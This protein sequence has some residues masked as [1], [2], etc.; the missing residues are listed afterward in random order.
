MCRASPPTWCFSANMGP[1]WSTTTGY[2]ASV[3]PIAHS[4]EL[5]WSSCRISL[6]GPALRPGRWSNMVGTRVPSP[7]RRQVIRH[8][9][10]SGLLTVRRTTTL[11]P[12]KL[13]GLWPL[14]RR[15]MSPTFPLRR[16]L[17]CPS[18]LL[19]ERRLALFRP[20]QPR[21]TSQHPLEQLSTVRHGHLLC[22]RFRQTGGD[23][24]CRCRCR[25]HVSPHRISLCN[26]YRT[27]TLG[28][29]PVVPIVAGVPI[30]DLLLLF[31]RI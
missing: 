28:R 17:R 4:V 24:P 16:R 13:L 5:A 29:D 3:S 12:G 26:R 25:Y 6:T 1:S 9:R 31:G 10:P 11:R 30:V 8:H 20:G 14:L 18:G 21:R 7:V 23:R 19:A 15:L 2:T 22:A 27:V